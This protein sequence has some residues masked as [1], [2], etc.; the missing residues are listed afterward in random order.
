MR[1]GAPYP[2]KR[3]ERL[4]QI[5]NHIEKIGS[6]PQAQGELTDR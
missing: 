1:A 5:A 2:R 4:S 3:R 6:S